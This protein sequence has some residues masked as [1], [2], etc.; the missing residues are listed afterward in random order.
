M[1]ELKRVVSNLAQ[2]LE[3]GQKDATNLVN[4]MHSL[5]TYLV[6]ESKTIIEGSLDRLLSRISAKAAEITG[7]SV[8]VLV[9]PE[10]RV[11]VEKTYT[12]EDTDPYLR[13]L[14]AQDFCVRTLAEFSDFIQ[15]VK[16]DVAEGNL[17]PVIRFL[18]ANTQFGPAP[19]YS[20]EPTLKESPPREPSSSQW[21]LSDFLPAPFPRPPL[22]RGLFKD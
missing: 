11:T 14:K 3:A 16:S 22:P 6:A 2:M 12:D 7:A 13:R 18:I 5:Q 15:S 10:M 17:I 20:P 8:V 9:S 1:D 19:V 4:T 21:K